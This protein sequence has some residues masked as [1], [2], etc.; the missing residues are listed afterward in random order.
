M[1]SG[2]QHLLH[3]VKEDTTTT[4]TTT[5]TNAMTWYGTVVVQG[6][7]WHAMACS[8]MQ[9]C[10]MVCSGMVCAVRFA[11][12]MS[13]CLFVFMHGC[14][15]IHLNVLTMHFAVRGCYVLQMQTIK[16]TCA[17]IY[18]HIYIILY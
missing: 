11:A 13:V 4:T 7:Q 8:G 2:V 14:A 3:L 9:W 5:T 10:A 17:Y 6:D 12:S 16:G 18:I 15:C 1:C